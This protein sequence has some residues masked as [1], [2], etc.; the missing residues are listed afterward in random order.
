MAKPD[1]LSY[2]NV[3]RDSS[4]KPL[5][6]ACAVSILNNTARVAKTRA[7]PGY[8]SYPCFRVEG[9]E[10]LTGAV[11]TYYLYQSG[12]ESF[13]YEKAR[14]FTEAM[15]KLCGWQWDVDR[16]LRSWVN[17]VI[18]TPFFYDKNN[19]ENGWNENWVLK[20][21]E[22][23]WQLPEGY[24]RFACY[25]AVCHVK[26]GPSYDRLTANEIFGYITALG[27]DLPAK[28]KKHGSGD[29]P[30]YVVEYKDSLL[31][32]KANDV[33]ATIKITL[34]E[35][36]EVHYRKILDFLCRLLELGFP[37]SY[38]IDFKSPEKNW[39][40]IKGL[41]KK[42][43]NQLFAN[44]IRWPSLQNAMERYA[45]LAMREDEWYFN[46]ENEDCAMPGTFAVFA[47][48]LADE[49]YHTLTCDYLN[50]CDGEHQSIQGKFLLAYIEKYGFTTKGLELYELCE[51]NIQHLPKKLIML[52]T[53]LS[54]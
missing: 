41:P 37:R 47:L 12:G 10:I 5:F 36:S 6:D 18:R 54:P 4:L 49:K 3:Q 26:Y 42:G 27:S 16:T 52:R 50:M 15:R 31:S 45:R 2:E 44:V 9:K 51:N 32:Y 35:E 19:S 1:Y 17:N 39:L 38:S 43:V 22:P 46:L 8:S 34:K 11:L 23:S 29:L 48:G 30:T 20:P 53:S 21:G 24:V 28:L 7:L 33:F 40:P 13:D 25:I 14:D